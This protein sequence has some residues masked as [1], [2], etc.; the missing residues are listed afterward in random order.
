[1]YDDRPY[2]VLLA[3]AIASSSVE[4]GDR[5]HGTEHFDLRDF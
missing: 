4:H 1:M 5:H 3:I 2:R